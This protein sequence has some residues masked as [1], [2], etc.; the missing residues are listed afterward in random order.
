MLVLLLLISFTQQMYTDQVIP[1][2]LSQN[3]AYHPQQSEVRQEAG[4][5]GESLS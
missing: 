1:S 2:S 3:H 5:P 4:R